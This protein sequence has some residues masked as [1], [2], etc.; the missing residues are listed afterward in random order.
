MPNKKL[1]ITDLDDTLWQWLTTWYS[2]YKGFIAYLREHAGVPEEQASETWARSYGD[3]GGIEFPPTT[4]YLITYTD[5]TTKEA[6][7]AY[8]GAVAASRAARDASLIMFDGVVDTLRTLA[9]NG[10]TVVAHTDS[11][12]TAAVHRLHTSGLDGAVKEVYAAPVFENFGYGMSLLDTVDVHVSQWEFKPSTR[13]LNEIIHY[14][15]VSPENTFYV[16]ESLRRDM[17]MARTAGITGLWAKYGLDYPGR[18]EALNAV[19][20]VQR[21][22]AFPAEGGLTATANGAEGVTELSEFSDVLAHVLG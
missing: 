5:L 21:Y 10:V 4:D 2:G 1:V 11:P 8:T 20:S 15:G 19:Y 13:V 14:Y 17:A 3:G 22:R 12:V 9:D 7:A 18:D 6:I 16:G